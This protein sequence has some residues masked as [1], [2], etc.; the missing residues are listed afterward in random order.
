MSLPDRVSVPVP[1]LA[2]P[3]AALPS[4]RLP[5][6]VLDVLSPPTLSTAA[7]APL[8][9]TMPLPRSELALL[10]K[11]LRSRVAL[12]RN[13]DEAESA[14]V[15]PAR[16]VPPVTLVA[17]PKLLAPVRVQ[18]EVSILLKTPKP[19]YCA[20]APTLVMSKLAAAVP[21]SCS[22]SAPVP[23]TAPVIVD[24][25]ARVKVFPLPAN[26]MAVVP[27]LIVPALKTVAPPAELTM[28]Y[29]P[30]LMTPPALFVTATPA[31]DNSVEVRPGDGAGIG[32]VAD[33]RRCHRGQTSGDDTARIVDQR[34]A[35]VACDTS[36]SATDFAAIRDVGGAAE[37]YSV[38]ANQ[39]GNDAA[40]KVGDR[41]VAG[42]GVDHAHSGK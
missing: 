14:P 32:D 33:S 26:W 28:A 31:L 10:S 25:C 17:P 39:R 42:G 5:L 13:A 7:T 27:P 18:I 8:L 16:N 37:K 6:K 38:L 21:P 3:S 41:S 15:E 20:A 36:A 11:P 35:A 34:D 40:G 9:V 1:V 24:P 23:T 4:C 30:A 2:K 29:L 19:R 22:V 12:T